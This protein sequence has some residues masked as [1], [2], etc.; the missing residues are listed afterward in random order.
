MTTEAPSSLSDT[1]VSPATDAKRVRSKRK[2]MSQE[3]FM[4]MFTLF[5]F[6]GVLLLVVFP[7]G[8]MARGISI[9]IYSVFVYWAMFRFSGKS[10]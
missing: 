7:E 10:S 4:V 9:G 5:F 3:R 8:S 2:G 6:A 1:P